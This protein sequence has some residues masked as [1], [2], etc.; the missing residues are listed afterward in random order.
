MYMARAGARAYNG[1]M[2][3]RP[4]QGPRGTARGGEP[5]GEAPWSWKAFVFLTFHGVAKFVFFLY[6]AL[7]SRPI[8]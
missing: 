8:P 3:Q 5:G 7:F 2:G 4:Q 6:F 1:G